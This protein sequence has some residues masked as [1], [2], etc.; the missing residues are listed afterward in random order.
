MIKLELPVTKF[1]TVHAALLCL[2]LHL[3]GFYRLVDGVRCI[4]FLDF[5]DFSVFNV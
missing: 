2:V 1:E 4:E 3:D 5:R